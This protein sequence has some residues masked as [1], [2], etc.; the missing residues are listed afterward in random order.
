MPKPKTLSGSIAL[1]TGSAGG[2]GKAIAKKF[3]DE[4]ACVVINDINGERLKDTKEEFNKQFGKDA[5]I[6]GYIDVTNHESIEKAFESA[7]LPL[8]EWILL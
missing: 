1:I 8:A 5:V 4:G 3:A 7:V 2:I 6:F